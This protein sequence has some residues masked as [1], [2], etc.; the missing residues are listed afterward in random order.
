MDGLLHVQQTLHVSL[1]RYP[2]VSLQVIQVGPEQS[3]AVDCY[4]DF[5]PDKVTAR[6]T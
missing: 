5:K 6:Y 3:A 1:P 2:G 4:D